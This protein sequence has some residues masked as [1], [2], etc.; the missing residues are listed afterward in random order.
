MTPKAGG[1]W[2]EKVLHNFNDN[3]KDGFFPYAGLIFDAAGNLY[4]TTIAGGSHGEGTVF[5]LTPKA[6]GNWTETI[7][8][9]FNNGGKD[10]N[11]PY[12]GLIL[13]AAGNLYG[14]TL[15]G[16]TRQRG[17]VRVNAQNGR[18]LGGEDSA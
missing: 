5:E 14:T 9:A 8:H 18:A 1:N 6:G 16:G 17:G 7:L 15:Q 12:V 10:G 3:G 2:T 4:G 11:S 13:D